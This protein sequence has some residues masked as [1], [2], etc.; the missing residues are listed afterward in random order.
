M[1]DVAR[2]QSPAP[3]HSPKQYRIVIRGELGRKFEGEFHGMTLE[4]G[5]GKT[6]LRGALDQPQ[7]HGV[8]GRIQSYNLEIIEVA[9]VAQSG[10]DKGE[11]S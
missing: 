9:E 10:E 3:G 2:N 4:S 1:H 7:L 6:L 11:T 5:D 8:L